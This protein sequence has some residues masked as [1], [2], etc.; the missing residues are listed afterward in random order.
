MTDGMH[1]DLGRTRALADRYWLD[2]L[3]MDPLLGTE[4]GD[5][6]FDDRL[7]D[8]SEAGLARHELAHRS[9]LDELATIDRTALPASDRGTM[10]VLEAIAT[11]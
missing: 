1:D 11:E 2:L 6:R 7:G 8:P 5:E 10:D 4:A 9:A 3:E